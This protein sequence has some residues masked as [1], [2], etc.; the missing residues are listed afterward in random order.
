MRVPATADRDARLAAHGRVSTALALLSDV[1]AAE[2]VA[3]AVPVGD[4]IGGRAGELEVDGTRVF[5]KR[6]PLTDL[7]LRPEHRRSTANLFGLPLF[8]QY[9]V[10]SC[11]FGAWRELAVHTMT[12]DWVLADVH[13]DFPLMHHWRVLP[14]TP[15]EGFVDYLGGIE[16]AVAHWDGSAAVRQRL[17]AIADSSASLVFFLEHVPQTLGAWLEAQDDLPAAAVWAERRL[18][19]GTAFMRERGLVHFDGHF[20]NVLTDG[21]RLYFADFG[22]ALSSR[23]E[24][25]AAER[26]FL[27]EH[28]HYDHFYTVSH[29]LRCHL[30]E[31]VRD[32]TEHLDFLRAWISGSRPDTLAPAVAG[33][34]DRHARTALLFDAFCGGLLNGSKSTPYP[35]AELVASL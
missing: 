25:S 7:E 17:E 11:G 12:T 28:R 1:R 13:P 2:L 19:R 23:F 34:V 6:V 18:E 10:G 26:A 16:G 35:A 24:L 3:T 4:G 15:P 31:G 20:A 21:R 29:L 32:R 33:L 22:L 8:Y 30:L 27:A 14:D 5:V 9:G